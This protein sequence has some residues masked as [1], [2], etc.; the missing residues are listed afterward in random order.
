MRR[1]CVELGDGLQVKLVND[2]YAQPFSPSDPDR[3]PDWAIWRK[4][5]F[6]ITAEPIAL[7]YDKRLVP[8][9]DVPR[10]RAD[11]LKLLITK[12]IMYHGKV[13]SYDAELSGTGFLFFSN[14]V[15]ITPSTWNLIRGLGQAGVRLYTFSH[16]IL[17]RVA[18]GEHLLAS[19]MIA[20][21]ALER[22]KDDPSID[23]T[24]FTDYTASDRRPAGGA[25]MWCS[26]Q[27]RRIASSLRLAAAR[28]DRRSLLPR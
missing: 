10:T 2:G 14:D 26:S 25:H 5:A 1:H 18:S 27:G 9:E 8:P 23:V 22:A 11:L 7:V 24:L 20:S 19:N 28:G 12:R 17:D 15:Q 16:T 3:I 13:A 6:G 21:Y 4:K